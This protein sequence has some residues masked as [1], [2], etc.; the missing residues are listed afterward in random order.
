[1]ADRL[2]WFVAHRTF[3]LNRET[4]GARNP[5]GTPALDDNI[6]QTYTG[7]ATWQAARSHKLDLLWS[8]NFNNRYH[9][10]DPP[11]LLVEDRASTRAVARHVTTGPRYTAILSKHV[12]FESA[13]MSRSGAGSFGYQ[14]ST[15]PTDIRI[16]D[17]I[18]NTATVAA[19]GYLL[20]PNSRLQFNNAVSIDLPQWHGSHTFKAGVQFAKQAFTTQDLHNGDLTIILNNGVP[21]SVRIY[22]TPT[23]A[24]S[25]T[26]QV[27]VFLQDDWRIGARLTLNLGGRIDFV[28]GWNAAE[29]LLAGR[30]VPARHFDQQNVLSQHIAVWRS[31]AVYD[32]RGDGRTALK[33][34]YS[35]YAAQVSIT[36]ATLVAPGVNSSGTRS[37]AD[38]NGDG[39]PQDSELGPFSGF[40]GGVN[41]RYTNPDGPQWPYSDEITAGVEHQLAGEVRVGLMFFRRS[42]RRNVGMHNI[43]VPTSAY[44]AQSI[45][46]PAAPTGPG[47]TAEFYNLASSYFGKQD[48]VLDVDSLLDTDYN[49]VE[50]TGSKRFSGRWQLTAGVTLGKTKGGLDKGVDLNDPNNLIY[51]QGIPTYDTTWAVKISGTYMAPAGISVSGSLMSTAGYPFQSVYSVTRSVFPSLTRASQAIP[52]SESGQERYPTVTLLDL[53]LSRQFKLGWRTS[54]LEPL[55]EVFN[56]TNASTVVTQTVNVGSNY[57]RPLE[58]LGPRLLRIGAR[59]QF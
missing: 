41:Q 21:N 43:A 7:K 29:D 58:I 57:L 12:V 3:R 42:N 19:P 39:I 53:R 38:S 24:D 44:T 40:S 11:L 32:L 8:V 55:I 6:Q 46:I 13:L 2:W 16:E 34:N 54:T 59:L 33:L 30:F 37:W 18:R 1:V 36:R 17:P 56:T 15:L 49:G 5:D 23:R 22:N 35:R 25:Y 20:R 51:Q 50:L 47:G 31:G 27:G 52:L 28:R 4:L 26:R 48:N 10:R 45:T 14:Q 9:R